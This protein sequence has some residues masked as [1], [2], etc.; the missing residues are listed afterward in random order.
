MR[1]QS[2]HRKRDPDAVWADVDTP[3]ALAWLRQ[4]RSHTLIHGHTHD[5]DRRT[6]SP[7]GTL[8]LH[9]GWDAWRGPVSLHELTR[10]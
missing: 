1:T 2:E 10:G 8:Q 4:T 3:A 7:A 9:V 5:T 6:T